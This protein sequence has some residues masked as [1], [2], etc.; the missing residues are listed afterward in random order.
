M[1]RQ[2]PKKIA[3]GK[4]LLRGYDNCLSGMTFVSGVINEDVF[5]LVVQVTTLKFSVVM[6]NCTVGNMNCRLSFRLY[7]RQVVRL[8]RIRETTKCN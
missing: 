3:R 2:W 4:E 8:L 1:S 7:K 5:P 6:R